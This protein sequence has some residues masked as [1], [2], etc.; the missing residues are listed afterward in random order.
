MNYLLD[1]FAKRRLLV[2]LLLKTPAIKMSLPNLIRVLETLSPLSSQVIN[3]V[4]T[5]DSTQW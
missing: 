4:L 2:E 3:D 1:S 5:K